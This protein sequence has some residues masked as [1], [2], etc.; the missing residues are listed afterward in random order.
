MTIFPRI[1]ADLSCDWSERSRDAS[2]AV[3]PQPVG[4][5]QASLARCVS[6]RSALNQTSYN[7]IEVTVEYYNVIIILLF[8][9]QHMS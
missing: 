7:N 3:P 6:L 1:E 4:A 9:R 5:L 2:F 8:N